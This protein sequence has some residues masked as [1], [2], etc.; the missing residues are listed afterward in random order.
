MRRLAA[1]DLIVS[2]QQGDRDAFR[3]LFEMHKDRV[4]LIALHFTG[5]E[6]TASDIVQQVF[7][8]LLR[9]IGK[10]HF[11][12]EF[13]TWLYRIVANACFDERRFWKRWV[14]YD[15]DAPEFDI[16]TTISPEAN[17]AN[18]EKIGEVMRAVNQLSPRLR[19]VVILKYVEEL[20]YLEIGRILG[21][22]MG[23][24]ASRLNRAHKALAER[25]SHLQS[26]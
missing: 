3:E 16:V 18:D 2:C 5:N 10:F 26:S 19:M 8:K 4:Y 15:S 25:L 21:C 23:T 24:V 20:S 14:Q 11:Q 1:D 9:D 12:A 22:S 6:S 17:L 7:L 13:T